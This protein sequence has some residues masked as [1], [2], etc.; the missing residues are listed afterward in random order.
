MRDLKKVSKYVRLND[1]ARDLEIK[2]RTLLA[3][4]P[5]IGISRNVNH[6]SSLTAE[7][8]AAV[9]SS[10]CQGKI[11]V[12]AKSLMNIRLNSQRLQGDPT[13][14]PNEA[15]RIY[16]TKRKKSNS[17]VNNGTKVGPPKPILERIEVN[18][19]PLPKKHN[20]MRIKVVNSAGQ[21][22]SIRIVHY[23]SEGAPIQRRIMIPDKPHMPNKSVTAKR[24][25]PLKR[26]KKGGVQI[27]QGGLPELGRR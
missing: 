1:I 20:T 27:V 6:A 2:T 26:T 9:I 16:Q 18:A 21:E 3:L 8:A 11:A 13:N 24:E 4:L 25:A 5:G 17:K 12:D 19:P 7:E 14:A 10:I 23:G 22:E 15:H